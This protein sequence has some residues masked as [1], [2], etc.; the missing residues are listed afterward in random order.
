MLWQAETGFW[1]RQTGAYLGALLPGDYQQDPLLAPLNGS[2]VPP[3]VSEVRG[4]LTARHVGAVIVAGSIQGY[5]T[6]LLTEVGLRGT[7]VGG[8]IVYPVTG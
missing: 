5:W 2:D 4:F 1:Y 6:H 8:V 3:S 7:T